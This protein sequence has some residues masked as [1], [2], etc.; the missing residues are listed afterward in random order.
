MQTLQL[1]MVQHH[2]VQVIDGRLYEVAE[3]Q[4]KIT[5]HVHSM[6]MQPY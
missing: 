4:L 6:K 2:Q 3:H 5:L 1:W